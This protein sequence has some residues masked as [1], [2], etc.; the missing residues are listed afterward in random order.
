[1]RSCFLKHLLCFIRIISGFCFLHI[2]NLCRF[3]LRSFFDSFGFLLS[4]LDHFNYSASR[5][6][7]AYFSGILRSKRK[8]V[9]PVARVVDEI[10]GVTTNF[11]LRLGLNLCLIIAKH[12]RYTASRKEEDYYWGAFMAILTNKLEI[13]KHKA[14]LQITI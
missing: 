2:E 7:V 5:K 13:E 8:H 11:P 14:K 10:Y 12:Y 6:K 3:L 9:R 4:L 1:M